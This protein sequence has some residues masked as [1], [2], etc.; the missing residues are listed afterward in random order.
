MYERAQVIEKKSDT[1]HGRSAPKAQNTEFSPSTSSPIDH[2]LTLQRTIGNQAVQKLFKSGVIQAKLKIGQPNDIYEQEADRVA[3]EVMQMPEP[4]LQRQVEPEEEEEEPIQT[5]PLADQIT[6]LVQRQVEPEEEEEKLQTKKIPGQIPEVT[7]ELES[8]IHSLKG[9]GQPLPEADR[10]FM[11]RKFGVDFSDVRGHTDSDAARMNRK[12]NAEAFTYGRNIYFGAG[13]Y[14]SGISSGKR[15]LAHELTHVVQQNGNKV[16]D[17]FTIVNAED[18]HEQDETQAHVYKQMGKKQ[19]TLHVKAEAAWVQR[20]EKEEKTL[21]GKIIVLKNI[22]WEPN[23]GLFENR[24]ITELQ[25]SKYGLKIKYRMYSAL[26]RESNLEKVTYG[27]LSPKGLAPETVTLQVDVRKGSEVGLPWQLFFSLLD[28]SVPKERGTER[29]EAALR[30]RV[31][32]T[33]AGQ[34]WDFGLLEAIDMIDSWTDSAISAIQNRRDLNKDQWIISFW[35]EVLAGVNLPSPGRFIGVKKYLKDARKM[36]EEAYRPDFR[37]N[38][39]W[40]ENQLDLAEHHL[41]LAQIHFNSASL[42][43]SS[44]R[45]GVLKGAELGKRITE[46]TIVVITAPT[47]SPWEAA[48]LSG[49]SEGALQFGKNIFIGDEINVVDIIQASATSYVASLISGK[50]RGLFD[51]SISKYGD[52]GLKLANK[53]STEQ[54]KQGIQLSLDG[55][56]NEFKGKRASTEEISKNLV[57][58][59]VSIWA[60]MASP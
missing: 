18:K 11:E 55:V 7:P 14:S 12:L 16:Q 43:W 25:K 10:S 48:L 34:E 56:F 41:K 4:R 26:M 40:V 58:R 28:F 59:A 19:E 15:L 8:R 17:K 27:G 36:I 51:K 2:I 50:L 22:P 46:L 54:L 42:G 35:S 38:P 33:L 49:V 32:L 30:K 52:E 21:R 47:G 20:K 44:Y 53:L 39:E 24:V 23:C 13:K 37:D 5:K 31:K 3:D 60:G 57:D 6:P 1:K 9:G 29:P 45:K